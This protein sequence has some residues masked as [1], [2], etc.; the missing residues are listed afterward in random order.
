MDGGMDGSTVRCGG[1]AGAAT[2]SGSIRQTDEA[3]PFPTLTAAA[4]SV[5]NPSLELVFDE[6]TA[7]A[8]TDDAVDA[9]VVLMM[10]E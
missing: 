2:D 3:H 9:G 4:A 5:A 6:F 10:T 7:G 8:T 1:G